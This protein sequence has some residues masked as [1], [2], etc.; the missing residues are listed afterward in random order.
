MCS[1]VGKSKTKKELI[2]E[3][4]C[5]CVCVLIELNCRITFIFMFLKI[6]Y[7]FNYFTLYFYDVYFGDQRCSCFISHM[8][9]CLNIN[10][11]KISPGKHLKPLKLIVLTFDVSLYSY[12]YLFISSFVPESIEGFHR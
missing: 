3:C 6:Q 2:I 8:Y 11:N 10:L 4:V 1:C 12:V 7:L 5:V 9:K